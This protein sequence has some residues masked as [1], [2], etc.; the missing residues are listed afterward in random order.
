MHTGA[1][2]PPSLI[3]ASKALIGTFLAIGHNRFELL[4][5]ELQEE[6]D[7]LIFAALFAL[8]AAACGMLAA[9]ALTAA[10][11]ASLWPH[12]VAAVLLTFAALYAGISIWL[13]RALTQR[14]R[15]WQTLAV[16]LDQF[17]KDRFLIEGSLP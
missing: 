13:F 11:V 1:E 10:V 6:R 8:G 4:A 9:I 2:I 17:R 14:L 3:K 15:D 5:I 7:R 16:T 12:H